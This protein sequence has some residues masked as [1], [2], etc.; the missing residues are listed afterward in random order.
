MKRRVIALFILVACGLAQAA[1][2]VRETLPDAS[3]TLVIDGDSLWLE[4]GGAMLEVRL[5][6]IDAP[7]ICQPWGP[8]A[9]DALR[10]LV[11]GKTVQ[12]RTV[13]KDSYGRT[14]ATLYVDGTL[15]VNRALVKEGNAWSTRVRY[16]RG[17]YVSEERMAKALG[18]GLNRAGDAMMP[19][20]FRRTHGPCTPGEGAALAATPPAPAVAAAVAA[21][22]QPAAAAPGFR[23]D[24]RTYC[25]QMRSCAEA[26]FFLNNC[27][28]V[29][30]D[31]DANGVPCERQWCGR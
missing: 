19:R 12:F 17:P 2:A 22:P 13:G 9:R 4:T 8:E 30:M 6:G 29:K 25:S 31:G 11:Q 26:T 21:P 18:R 27:P 7:E 3:A 20:D 10:D 28:G 14:L 1:G 16:D 24:G 5:Q 23:C 15:E